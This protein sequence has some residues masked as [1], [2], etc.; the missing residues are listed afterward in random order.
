VRRFGLFRPRS[1][2]VYVTA[3]NADGATGQALF[4]LNVRNRRL[5]LSPVRFERWASLSVRDRPV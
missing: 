5:F 2:W 4:Y 1:Q 3:T